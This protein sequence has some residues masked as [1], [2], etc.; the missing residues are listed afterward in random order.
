MQLLILFVKVPNVGV[1]DLLIAL[2]FDDS[3]HTLKQVNSYVLVSSMYENKSNMRS[4]VFLLFML[5]SLMFEEDK[6][7]FLQ[8][9]E[10]LPLFYSIAHRQNRSYLTSSTN[11]E[12]EKF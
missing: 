7:S 3:G 8:L 10:C 9:I 1:C 11:D 6:E 4:K 12:I 2:S 5:S